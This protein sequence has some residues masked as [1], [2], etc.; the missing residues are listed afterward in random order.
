MISCSNEACGHRM[1]QPCTTCGKGI[2]KK[3]SSAWIPPHCRACARQTFARQ[4]RRASRTLLHTGVAFFLGG[5]Y[6]AYGNMD[7]HSGGERI[8]GFILLGAVTAGIMVGWKYFK[9]RKEI[10]YLSPKAYAWYW[11][12]RLLMSAFVGFF[13]L[14]FAVH[15]AIVDFFRAKRAESKLVN[16][17]P[18]F[19]S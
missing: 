7:A 8:V 12:V 4:R 19:P 6:F 14:P 13:M 5:Y 17:Q 2:C 1:L 3:C 15:A 18:F 11:A 16:N 10:V 9:S